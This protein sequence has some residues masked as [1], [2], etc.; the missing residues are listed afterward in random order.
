MAPDKGAVGEG[1]PDH[2]CVQP[3]DELRLGAPDSSKGCSAGSHVL[4]GLSDLSIDVVRPGQLVIKGDAKVFG[5]VFPLQFTSLQV[6]FRKFPINWDLPSPGES[7]E[8]GFF[9]G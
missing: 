1:R 8:M 7:M 5:G 6:K 4:F 9:S 3:F 2:T